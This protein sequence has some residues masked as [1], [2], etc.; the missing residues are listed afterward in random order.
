ML[1]LIRVAAL[2]TLLFTQAARATPV[3]STVTTTTD[4]APLPKGFPVR[5]LD[6]TTLANI[7]RALGVHSDTS[8][9]TFNPATLFLCN[10]LSCSTVCQ[11]IAL[12]MALVDEC[13]PTTIFASAGIVQ[14]ANSGLPFPVLVGTP[15]CAS[16]AQIPTVNECF[17]F[18]GTELSN[19]DILE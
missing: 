11:Q 1:A 15:E 5:T 18:G 19:Y 12:N 7:T 13:V 9:V 17:N 3:A 8:D 6:L 16:V 10:D 14:A 4:G 2:T